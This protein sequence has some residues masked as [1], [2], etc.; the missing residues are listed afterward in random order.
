MGR[1]TAH[2]IAGKADPRRVDYPGLIPKLQTLLHE[3]FG[4]MQID[5]KTYARRMM[6][7]RGHGNDN[8]DIVLIE[9]MSEEGNKWWLILSWDKSFEWIQEL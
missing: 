2:I 7:D 4:N 6:N 3:Y 8:E 1:T 5:V 9:P